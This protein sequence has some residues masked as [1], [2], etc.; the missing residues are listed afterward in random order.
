MV[1][2]GLLGFC[3]VFCC[4]FVFCIHY[5]LGFSASARAYKAQQNIASQKKKDTYFNL[6]ASCT[7][8]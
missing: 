5:L 1:N 3:W 2:V 7:T 4:L 8:G 6:K